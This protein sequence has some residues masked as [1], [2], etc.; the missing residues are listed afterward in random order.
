MFCCRSSLPAC[1]NVPIRASVST[2]PRTRPCCSDAAMDLADGPLHHRVP[3]LCC[4]GGLA[5]R[6]ASDLV[7]SGDSRVGHR[8]SVSLR[9]L[10]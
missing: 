4:P 2:T 3:G 6:L 1:A 8:A 5:S 10:P 7:G 9:Q